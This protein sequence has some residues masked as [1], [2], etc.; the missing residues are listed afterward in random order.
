MR[1]SSLPRRSSRGP[2][3]K[4]S[5]SNRRSNCSGKVF[6]PVSNRGVCIV[7][8]SLKS[9]IYSIWKY[10]IYYASFLIAIW[11]SLVFEKKKKKIPKMYE[12][13]K[14]CFRFSLYLYILQS[15]STV[16]LFSPFLCLL[17]KS[18]ITDIEI[19][20]PHHFLCLVLEISSIKS[21]TRLQ[22]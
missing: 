6:R 14:S 8:Y 15:I 19:N 17:L 12:K 4:P 11:Y 18:F 1:W 10:D 20:F 5:S 9:F 2:N 21:P 16:L 7:Q 13:K 22:R 3:I